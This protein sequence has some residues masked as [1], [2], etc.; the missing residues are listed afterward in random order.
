M[1]TAIARK[2]NTIACGVFLRG[3]LKNMTCNCDKT[4]MKEKVVY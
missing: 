3:K 1:R 4:S 2:K